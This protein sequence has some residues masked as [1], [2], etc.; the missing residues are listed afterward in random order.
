MKRTGGGRTAPRAKR[1][2]DCGRLDAAT[3]PREPWPL[4]AANPPPGEVPWA[5][6]A[7][8]ASATGGL[9][10]P[11]GPQTLPA[12]D[13]LQ[14]L[15]PLGIRT[16]NSG[17]RTQD[18]PEASQNHFARRMDLHSRSDSGASVRSREQ[19]GPERLIQG[20]RAVLKPEQVRSG[21]GERG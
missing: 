5:R 10:G 12:E 16:Q 8:E 17:L 2:L 14:P 6:G 19:P 4:E 13:K 18:S 3:G 20:G 21:D 9:P 7:I 11:L 1:T 15:T